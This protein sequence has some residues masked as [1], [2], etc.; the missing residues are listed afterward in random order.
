[1]RKNSDSAAFESTYA[2][3]Q[4]SLPRPNFGSPS[5]KSTS[6]PDLPQTTSPT[7]N[8]SA[9]EVS[10]TKSKPVDLV[11]SL[12]KTYGNPSECRKALRKNL[13]RFNAVLNRESSEV[14]T[15][16]TTLKKREGLKTLR[17]AQLKILHQALQ[18]GIIVVEDF[19][20]HKI[21]LYDDESIRSA[22]AN[23]LAEEAKSEFGSTPEW[24][25]DYNALILDLKALI[26]D[27]EK[28][29]V[30]LKYK[31]AAD[32]YKAQAD[33]LRN[34]VP[35]LKS[36]SSATDSE[37]D[38]QF[39][40]ELSSSDESA[41]PKKKLLNSVEAEETRKL[42]EEYQV[43]NKRLDEAALL[44]S[45]DLSSKSGAEIE[46][47]RRIEELQE[48]NKSAKALSV[49]DQEIAE[50]RATKDKLSKRVKRLTSRLSAEQSSE[51]FDEV[52][53][54][55]EAKHKAE[56]EKQAQRFE[57][58]LEERDRVAK[59]REAVL[60]AELEHSKHKKADEEP[61]DTSALKRSYDLLMKKY[62][63]AVQKNRVLE[64]ELK[65]SH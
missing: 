3:A 22:V 12:S 53:E 44:V 17:T 39:D 40:V 26:K 35:E 27:K 2:R 24:G 18:K 30:F 13:E 51:K 56:L 48:L 21:T 15:S 6:T 14:V 25:G 59:E 10:P 55:M 34:A 7:K 60:R 31:S 33:N 9:E 57:K 43:L 23:V 29:F 58:M 4:S 46:S 16:F 49:K 37:S 42:R 41:S 54:K 38:F 20:R 11:K 64:E 36:D 52:V 61:K 8:R 32:I 50:L 62:Q 5:S 65:F 1:M 19:E 47:Q 45:I 63:A 28:K